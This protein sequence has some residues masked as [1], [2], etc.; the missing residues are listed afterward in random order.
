M[1]NKTIMLIVVAVVVW[2]VWM[3]SG[4]KNPFAK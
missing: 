3:K 1:S 2:F 4:Y